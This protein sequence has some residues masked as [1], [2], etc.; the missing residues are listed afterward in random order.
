[1]INS[2][3]RKYIVNLRKDAT[4]HVYAT[5]KLLCALSL[6]NTSHAFYDT[7]SNLIFARQHARRELSRKPLVFQC[8]FSKWNLFVE[9]VA[10]IWLSRL[11]PVNI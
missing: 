1:M 9:F 3:K 11:S 4:L 2:A 7:Q 10:S 8:N 5:F 6:S